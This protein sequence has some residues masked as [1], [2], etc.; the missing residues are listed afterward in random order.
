M[1]F[2]LGTFGCFLLALRSSAVST[3]GVPSYGAPSLVSTSA[4][5]V[6]SEVP[7]GVPSY[8]SPCTGSI[9]SSGNRKIG[10][11]I[12]SSGSNTETDPTDLRIVAGKA[13]VAN[14]QT[15]DQVTVI[16]FDDLFR[17]VS[18]LGPPST[19]SFSGI[20]SIG[21]TFIAGGVEAAITEISKDG[22]GPT[23]KVSGIVVL[24]DGQDSG[25]DELVAQLT[26]AKGLGI[27][28]SFGFLDPFNSDIQDP[29]ILTAIIATGGI[30]STIDSAVAQ[31]SFVNL[32]LSHGLTA[33]D[34]GAVGDKT[35]LLP[36]LVTAGNVSSADS[37]AKFTYD[38]VAHEKLKFSVQAISE[39]SFDIKL[40][41]KIGNSDIKGASTDSTGLATIEYETTAALTLEL[42]VSTSNS[43]TGLFSISLVSSV[44][45][46]ISVCGVTPVVNRCVGSFR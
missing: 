10:I 25:I 33:A 44:N 32:V 13:I 4:P 14:L 36:G 37:P 26:R 46:T 22:S 20:D 39:Q 27:R 40:V 19:A 17:I 34:G 2:K 45:R 42:D 9:V 28:V 6:V 7:H 29:S 23:D 31:G 38:A 11:V 16:D 12:D 8:A 43:T 15:S 30:Y 18:P 21:G 3:Y 35:L 41:D 5:S 24:T 1:M